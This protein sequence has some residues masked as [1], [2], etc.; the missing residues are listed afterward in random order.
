MVS[1]RAL[2]WTLIA[3]C[4]TAIALAAYDRSRK[5]R[6]AYDEGVAK[7]ES[8]QQTGGIQFSMLSPSLPLPLGALETPATLV[9]AIAMS[10]TPSITEVHKLRQDFPKAA[11]FVLIDTPVN[12]DIVSEL[13]SNPRRCHVTISKH[14]SRTISSFSDIVGIDSISLSGK[15]LTDSE[16]ETL[17]LPKGCNVQISNSN[18]SDAG[19]KQLLEKYPGASLSVDGKRF[20]TSK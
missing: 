7:I 15:W 9:R 4:S 14:D 16:L 18:V 17:V 11:V 1:R 12:Q 5:K 13:S 2:L 20:P 8:W 19:Y 6:A 3:L 10:R